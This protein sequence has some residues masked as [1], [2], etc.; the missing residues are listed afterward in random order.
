MICRDNSSIND[1]SHIIVYMP[2]IYMVDLKHGHG[3]RAC[4]VYFCRMEAFHIK[5]TIRLMFK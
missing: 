3:Q 5:K 2:M 4:G 1:I